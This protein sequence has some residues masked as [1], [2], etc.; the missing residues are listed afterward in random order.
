VVEGR[1][2]A[3]GYVRAGVRPRPFH[4]KFLTGDLGRI[5]GSGRLFL[6]G[7]LDQM[8]NVGGR[9]VFPAEVERVL[10]SAPGVREVAILG[11][12][13]PLRGEV[14]AAV[15]ACTGDVTP[16]DLIAFCRER[17]AAYRVPRRIEI[18][19]VIPRT[20]RGKVDTARLRSLL[21]AR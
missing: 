6:E 11:M 7:R 12:P 18:L 19:P 21:A 8:I 5:D 16:E 13:D 3:L 10:G 4:R 1:A 2:V 14:V 15:V 17:L 9:N 20:A